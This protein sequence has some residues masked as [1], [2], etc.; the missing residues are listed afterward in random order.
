MPSEATAAPKFRPQE[1]DAAIQIGYGLAIADINGDAKIDI[2]LADKNQIVWYQNPSWRKHVVAENLTERD[3]VCVAAQDING[4]GKAE[5]AVGAGWNPGD[6]NH[7]GSVHYLIPPED[8]TQRWTP[9]AL[10]H[11]PTV[12]RMHWVQNERN[13][14]ELAVLPIHGR[15]NRGGKGAGVKLLAYHVP[16]NP[17]DS[18]ETRVINDELHVT[19]NFDPGQWDNDAAAELLIASREGVFISDG[20]NGAKGLKIIGNDQGGGAGEVRKGSLGEDKPYIISIEP[21][22]GNSVVVYTPKVGEKGMWH[23][24]VIDDS[25]RDGHAIVCG[26]FADIGRDQAAVGW[27]AMRSGAP[28]GIKLFTPDKS[29]MQWKVSIVDHNTMACE[30]L[31]AA[32]LNG[33]DRL[34]L[35]AAGRKTRNVKIYWNEGM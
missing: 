1:I 16:E 33:D 9:I 26:D 20:I 31:K 12:H 6:T 29:G 5:I 15:G 2:V 17:R 32:D 27:R 7:S 30:D 21:M 19:H 22:H 13:Q 11:E 3:H 25:L 14:W 10:H 34:D 24:R 35:I 18:W 8:R 23:R 28:V 4:D